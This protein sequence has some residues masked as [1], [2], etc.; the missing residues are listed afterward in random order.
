MYLFHRSVYMEQLLSHWMDIHENWYWRIFRKYVKSIKLSLNLTRMTGTTHEEQYKF[1]IY[2]A[3]FF[4]EREIF[5]VK[6]AEKIKPHI[7]YSITF[8]S[9]F[10]PFMR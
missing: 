7:L 1:F 4:L 9:T 5:Q 3:Q 10:V 8:V 2:L 6:V